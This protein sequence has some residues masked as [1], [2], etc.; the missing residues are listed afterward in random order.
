MRLFTLSLLLSL[1][2]TL[3]AERIKD[4]SALE[5]SEVERLVGYGVVVGLAGTGDSDK[6][7]YH[8]KAMRAAMNKFQLSSGNQQVK[9][10][11]IAGVML[12]ASLPPFSRKGHRFMVTVSS[13]GDSKS[14]SG[15]ELLMTTLLDAQG[16]TRAHV[17]GAVL[18]GGYALQGRGGGGKIKNHPTV[19]QIPDGG[20]VVQGRSRQLLRDGRFRFLLHDADITTAVRMAEVINMNLGR[21]QAKAIDPGSVEVQL[22]ESHRGRSL[23]FLALIERLEITP[24]L[25]AKVVISERTGT[26]ILGQDVQL[27]PAAVAHGNLTVKISAVEKAVPAAPL[28]PG[29]TA[30]EKNE[31]ISVDEEEENQVLLL[32]GAPR[33]SDVVRGLNDL[34]A[35]V[36]DLISILEALRVSGALR[37]TIEVI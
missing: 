3:Q 28:T 17:Q 30:L 13:M 14:L 5:G 26:L 20:Q 6:V 8:H 22:P 32:R 25:R 1:P 11:N 23:E 31:E 27:S 33:L 29:D 16:R 35:S 21:P 37:A 15:G 4:L 19:G 36:R 10:K 9:L 12:T 2:S 7:V 24:D 34:G 18:V